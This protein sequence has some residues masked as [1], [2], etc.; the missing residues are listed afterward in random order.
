MRSS[1]ARAVRR[2]GL[3]RILG[4]YDVRRHGGPYDRGAADAYYER[5]ARPHYFVGDTYQ[6][7]EVPVGRMTEDER[8]QYAQGYADTLI[9]FHL[10]ER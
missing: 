5:P 9:A 6:S 2:E 4:H 3:P 10:E 1:R 8:A 7:E